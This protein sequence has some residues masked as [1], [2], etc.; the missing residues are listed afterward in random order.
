M[1]S[2]LFPSI[3][4]VTAEE[5]AEQ[6]AGLAKFLASEP[7]ESPGLKALSALV[8][9]L[10]LQVALSSPSSTEVAQSSTENGLNRVLTHLESALVANSATDTDA[11]RLAILAAVSS[12]S[13]LIS[14]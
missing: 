4:T 5:L 11:C 1:R 3:T 10:A 12:V 14:P 9:N 8:A 7:D 13:S 2:L 6:A